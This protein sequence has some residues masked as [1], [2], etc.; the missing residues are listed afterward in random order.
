V[1]IYFNLYFKLRVF[2]TTYNNISFYGKGDLLQMP[3]GCSTTRALLK[4]S[5]WMLMMILLQE[6]AMVKVYIYYALGLKHS[7]DANAVMFSHVLVVVT[8]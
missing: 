3:F 5:T 2:L 7:I 4:I 1:G 6:S 8:I